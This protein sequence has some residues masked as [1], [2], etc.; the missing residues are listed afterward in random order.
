M[1]KWVA[2]FLAFSALAFASEQEDRGQ[3]LC[4]FTSN[5]FEILSEE[6]RIVDQEKLAGA[7]RMF[8]TRLH[9]YEK[10]PN[11]EIADLAQRFIA[12][13][14]VGNESKE[15]IG[16]AVS[17]LGRLVKCSVDNDHY[18]YDTAFVLHKKDLEKELSQMEAQLGSRVPQG[19]NLNYHKIMIES[20]ADQEYDLALYSYLKIAETRCQ[21]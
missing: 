12:S 9:Q 8:I 17:S 6:S 1:K 3:E 11:P 20:L 4:S 15:A 7:Y 18:R 5:I 16:E 14:Q 21:K 10:D 19:K 2:T 13:F